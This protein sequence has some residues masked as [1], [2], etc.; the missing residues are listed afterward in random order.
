MGNL[1]AE[2]ELGE[3]GLFDIV[4]SVRAVQRANGEYVVFF[5]DDA[6]AKAVMFRWMP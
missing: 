4:Q 5:E 2:K 6:K 1:I 3:I